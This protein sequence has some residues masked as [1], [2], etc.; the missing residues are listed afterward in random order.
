[1]SQGEACQAPEVDTPPVRI[2]DAGA[3]GAAIMFFGIA[4]VIILL[5]ILRSPF[6]TNCAA[7]AVSAATTLAV[8]TGLVSM[9]I[10][11]VDMDELARL[12][13]L[14]LIPEPCE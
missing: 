12:A 10:A 7:A 2:P 13:T 9:G 4:T 3:L 1:M 14:W 5:I 8:L 11:T 6:K